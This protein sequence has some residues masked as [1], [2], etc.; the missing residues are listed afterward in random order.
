MAKMTPADT[1]D[2]DN[3]DAAEQPLGEPGLKALQAER[4]ARAEAEKQAKE[5]AEKLAAFEKAE[6]EKQDAELTELERARKDAAEANAA[7]ETARLETARLAALAKYPVPEEYQ[8]LVTGKDAEAFEASAK[9]LH[10]LHAKATSGG[11]EVFDR[12]MPSTGKNPPVTEGS[13]EAGA[14]KARQKFAQK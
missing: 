7:L 1:P 10:E 9:K 11:K 5:L 6:Q 3:Q 2:Q 14:E 12:S 8:D 4:D 13:Y